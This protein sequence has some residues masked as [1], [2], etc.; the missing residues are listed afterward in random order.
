V[1]GGV[2]RQLKQRLEHLPHGLHHHPICHVGNPQPSLPAARLGDERPTNLARTPPPLKQIDAQPRKD[3]RPLRSQRPDRHPVRARSA[4]VRDHLQQRRAE[5]LDDLIHRRGHTRPLSDDRL[6]HSGT[7]PSPRPV[8]GSAARAPT[9]GFCCRDRQPQLRYRFI[10]R[11]RLPLP[12]G[13][14]TH[15][16]DGHYPAVRYYAI[17]RLLLGHRPSSFRPQAYRPALSSAGTRQISRGKSLRFRGDHVANTP[18]AP[19][20]TGH[21][22]RRPARPPRTPSRR[23]TLVRHHRASTASFR[24][25][26]TEAHRHKDQ[27]PASRPVNSGPRPCLIDV[28]FPLSG[29]QVRTHTSD[30]NDMP[31]TPGSAL[32]AFASSVPPTRPLRDQP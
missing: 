3:G 6:R 25:A 28:G 13:A 29:P 27:P 26:L 5:S 22:C 19:T 7:R 15:G 8:R 14:R 12:T 31:G 23:F 17:L 16:L 4:L 20:G 10:D 18:L 1:T 21:R 32:R 24:P 9:W 2:E 30:L 11:D